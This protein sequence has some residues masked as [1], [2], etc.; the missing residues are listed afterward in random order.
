M[1]D[2]AILWDLDGVIVDTGELHFNAWKQTLD[3]VGFHLTDADFA[4]VNGM[5]NKRIILTLLGNKASEA[6]IKNLADKKESIF[7]SQKEFC[8]LFPHVREWLEFFKTKQCKQAVA[9]SAPQINIDLLMDQFQIKNYFDLLQSSEGMAGKPDP[10]LFLTVAAKLDVPQE[11]CLVIEDSIAGIRAAKQAGMKCLALA[12]SYPVTELKQA[13][14]VRADL[15][16]VTE[17]D[18]NFL[19]EI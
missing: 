2:H 13:D 6:E 19:L 1:R 10:Q 17:Q 14:L 7:R 5:N 11:N 4:R 12:T 16:K 9:S 3:T 8:K 15:T 18:I